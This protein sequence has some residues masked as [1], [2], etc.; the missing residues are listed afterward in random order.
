MSIWQPG[1]RPDWVTALNENS[2]PTW[3]GL[4]ADS[5]LDE[6]STR[7]G[8]RDFG[9]DAFLE[10]FR[11][12]VDALRDEAKLHTIGALL[13]R[14]DSVLLQAV[15]WSGSIPG[16][17]RFRVPEIPATVTL[18][19]QRLKREQTQ[20]IKRSCEPAGEV[21]T[22]PKCGFPETPAEPFSE[23][24]EWRSGGEHSRQSE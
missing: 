12:F 9:S 14:D 18:R 19:Q 3:I 4:E 21:Q 10:P 13:I 22:Q 7:T 11:I 8:L 20:R 15:H 6:A 5:L 2:D 17:W 23:S 1:P 24:L 16:A